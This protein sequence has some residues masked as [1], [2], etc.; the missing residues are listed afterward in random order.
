MAKDDAIARALDR[1]DPAI[2]CYLL[3][4]PD[5]AA[6]RALAQRLPAALGPDAERVDL[7]AA[8]IAADPALLADEAASFGMFGGRRYIR[9]EGV[10]DACVGAVEA[11]LA[12]PV[13]G[14]PA[15]LIGGALRKD[16]K[17]VKLLAG[18]AAAMAHA[19]WPGDVNIAKLAIDLGAENGLRIDLDVARRLARAAGDD[20]A[21]LS[22]EIEKLALYAD[23]SREQP[24]AVDHA[25][26]DTIGADMG[27]GEIARFIDAVLGGRPEKLGAEIAQLAGEGREGVGLIRAVLPSLI[28]LAAL[29]AEID[30]GASPKEAVKRA[31]RGIFWKDEDRWAGYATRWSAAQIA[32]A[33]ERVS[34]AGR[35]VMRARGSGPIAVEAEFFAIA[36]QADRR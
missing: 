36:R 20:R 23:A 13:A 8:R 5:E 14:N 30:R 19:S 32:R 4:G 24:R 18:H 35:D 12:A 27:D 22:S 6:S 15:V 33:I 11:L 28:Q 10:T 31:G 17:L 26:L 29:R 9:V 21:V 2:R 7:D 16:A 1:A 3:Y 25:M 34:V